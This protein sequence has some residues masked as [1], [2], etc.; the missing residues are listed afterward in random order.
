MDET[1]PA[2]GADDPQQVTASGGIRLP[3]LAPQQPGQ[4]DEEDGDGE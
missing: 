2:A 3:Q 1:P 4:Q